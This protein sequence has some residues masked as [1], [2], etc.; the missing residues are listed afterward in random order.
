MPLTADDI[1]RAFAELVRAILAGDL[2]AARELVAH[3]QRLHPEWEQLEQPLGLSERELTIAAGIAELLAIRAGA[4][5]PLWTQ[6]I[7]PAHEMIILD[8]GLEQMPRSFARAKTS[9]PEALRRRN[10]IALPDFLTVA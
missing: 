4:R 1:R 6:A 3:A 10:L 9:G 5:P 7:G 8:P 2:I